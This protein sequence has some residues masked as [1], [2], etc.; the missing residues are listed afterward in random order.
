MHK[1]I[2]P[3]EKLLS[4]IK[5]KRDDVPAEKSA[6]KETDNAGKPENTRF[7]N[8]LDN[9]VS[10]ILKSSLFKNNL[11]SPKILRMFNRYMTVI[12]VIAF[13]Y[14]ISDILF[15][16][17]SRKAK[18]VI[19]GFSAVVT[20]VPIAKKS[21]QIE[22]NTYSYYSN[23]ISGKKIF[24]AGSYV[25]GEA[26]EGTEAGGEEASANLALVG[27]IPGNS[28]QAI[29][30]DKKTQKTYYLMKGQTTDDIV[31]EEIGSDKV[32]IEYRGKRINL[33]L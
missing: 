23:R 2:S 28:P 18:A 26:A 31:L 21:A 22:A 8:I 6:P 30:E 12:V 19:S 4:I 3:E 17:P 25:P 27:I 32:T 20:P 14:F 9:Y 15:V 16:R 5:G 13:V 7:G 24:G 33:F 1:D 29:I 11:F 10:R